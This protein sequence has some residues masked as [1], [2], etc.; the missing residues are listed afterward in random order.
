MRSKADSLL[1]LNDGMKQSENVK[2]FQNEFK[3]WNG[4]ES[5]FNLKSKET[6]IYPL[7]YFPPKMAEFMPPQNWYGQSK[8]A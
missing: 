6:Y 8:I 7:N 5:I 1:S 3:R 4:M 2:E